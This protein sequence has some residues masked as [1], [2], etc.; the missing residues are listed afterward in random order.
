VS[1]R[2]PGS[3]LDTLYPR[4]RIGDRFFRGT[5]TSQATAVVSGIAA[6]LLQQ[7]PDLRPD[8]VKALLKSGA[9][10]LASEGDAVEA[11][12]SG[13]VDAARSAD[14]A[15]PS[16]ADAAQ[17]HPAAV[18]DKSLQKVDKALSRFLARLTGSTW[19]GSTWSGSTWSGSTWSGSTW[20][21]STWSGSTW[22]GST[23]SGST[24][25]SAGWGDE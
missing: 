6:L 21:G 16:P 1:L 2:A 11:Q 22:S 5:G 24:W 14:L 9:Q 20:S 3:R 10:P 13:A 7:R 15:A 8:Q 25:S 17:D 12:G 18:L 4:A 23:W 19:S